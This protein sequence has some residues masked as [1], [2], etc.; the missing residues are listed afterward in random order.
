MNIKLDSYVAEG[1]FFLPSYVFV[2]IMLAGLPT[3]ITW[4]IYIVFLLIS[5]FVYRVYIV[6][7]LERKSPYVFLVFILVQVVIYFSASCN[8]FLAVFYCGNIYA[9]QGRHLGCGNDIKNPIIVLCV[10]LKVFVRH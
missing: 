7:Y 9:R 1:A 2:F 8:L 10:F 6:C 3:A 5:G 4:T